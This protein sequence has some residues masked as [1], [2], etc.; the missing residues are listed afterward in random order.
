MS[1]L[2]VQELVDRPG[3]DL[4]VV[5][6]AGTPAMRKT[7]TWALISE[8][9]DPSSYVD[10]GELVLTTGSRIP[11]DLEARKQYVDRLAAAGAVALGFGTTSFYSNVP[12]DL[13]AAAQAAQLPLISVPA[14][15]RFGTISRFVAQ[16]ISD[17]RQKEL[18]FAV[19]AQRDLTRASLSPYAA[20]AMV[21]RLAKATHSWVL[22]LDQDGEL[23]AG[24]PAA[25][26]HLARIRIDLPRLREQGGS[27]SLS[28]TVAGESVVLFPLIVRERIRGYL[29]V[30]RS[31][32]FSRAEHAVLGTAVSLLCA[33]LHSAWGILDT[34]RRQRRAV[35]Q[36]A[37]GGNVELAASIAESLDSDFPS[38]NLRVALLGAPAGHELELLEQ[39]EN[40]HGLRSLCALVAEWERGRVVVVMP[41]AEGDIR[42]LESLLRGIPHARGAVSDPT[43]PHELPEAWKQVRTVFTSASGTTGK[44]ALASDVVT[45]GVLRHLNNAEARGWAEALLAPLSDKSRNPKVD[46]RHTLRTFLANNGQ[47]D[48][49]ASALGVHRHT[50]RHRMGKVAEALGVNIDDPTTR[51]ELWIAL[52]LD[53]QL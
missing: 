8:L 45:A 47:S 51:A 33:D 53:D 2:T 23:R 28:M 16:R 48:A 7:L 50:L 43:P 17:E 42:T 32:Q 21:E 27:S 36:A 15:T 4:S 20:R 44:L 38:G 14:K 19:A 9:T 11:Q 37:I 10:G 49:S 3:L 5:A 46:L 6:G 13:V 35:F 12:A 31:T 34:Q 25:R 18:K 41:P 30:G 40:D 52:Q 26:M 29:A 24:V 1:A 39:A 22:L